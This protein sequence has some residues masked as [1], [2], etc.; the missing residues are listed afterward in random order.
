[1]D[2]NKMTRKDFMAVKDRGWDEDVGLFDSLVIL[3]SRGYHDSGYRLLDFV[4]VKGC[5]PICKL[6]GCSDVLHI[7]G[8][9]GMGFDWINKYG[10]CP[11]AVPPV[12]WSI[13]CLPKSGL[14]RL[15]S[16]Q[17]I[18]VGAALSSFEVFDRRKERGDTN[19]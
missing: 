19:G 18:S 4:A 11:K 3:P 14:L 12:S 1:M 2:I 6:S 7:N 9:S 13:D 8:I 5:E 10:S 17:D 16:G 15:F